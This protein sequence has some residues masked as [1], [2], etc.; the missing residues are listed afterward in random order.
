[1][2]IKL[3]EK[4]EELKD[5]LASLGSVAVAFSGGV[6]STFLL[7]A[8][9]EALKDEVIAVTAASCSF[10]ERERKEAEGYCEKLGVRHFVVRSEELQIEGF[11]QNPV[12]RCYLCKHE[13]FGK[14]RDLAAKQGV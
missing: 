2:D 14:I 5:Y 8:A 11:A 9:R 13:L 12:N 10:P 1:M 3:Q 6:D 4:Y 7:Y